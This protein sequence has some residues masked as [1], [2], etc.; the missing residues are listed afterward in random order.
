[1]KKLQHLD[2]VEDVAQVAFDRMKGKESEIYDDQ[3]ERIVDGLQGEGESSSEHKTFKAYQETP[4]SAING[5]YGWKLK[6][7]KL[8]AKLRKQA[9]DEIAMLNRKLSTGEWIKDVREGKRF[10]I[11]ES[12]MRID[13]LRDSIRLMD[14]MSQYDTLPP[15]KPS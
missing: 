9:E 8:R 10:N 15:Q 1:M 7:P 6:D 4:D 11:M 3:T 2:C 14:R 12:Y 13:E 5:K